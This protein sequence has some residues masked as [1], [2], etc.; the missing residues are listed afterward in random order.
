MLVGFG[1]IGIF[2]LGGFMF[3]LAAIVTNWLVMPRRPGRE[4]EKT[5]ECGLDTQGP[6]GCHPLFQVHC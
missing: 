1:T 3:A 5:Y 2:L 4:K 6:T